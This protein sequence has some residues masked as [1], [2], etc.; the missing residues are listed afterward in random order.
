MNALLIGASGATGK[1]LLELLLEDTE[2]TRVDIFVRRNLDIEH[3]KL[4]I[5]I[6]DFDKPEQWQ[7][8]VHGDVLF[9][10]LGTTLKAAGSKEA[11]MKIDHDYQLQFARAAKQNNLTSYVLVSSGLASASSPFFYTRMKGLLEDH[12][13]VLNFPKIIIFNPPAL[14]RMHSDRKMEVAAIKV[15]HFFNSLGMFRSIKPLPTNVLAK[16]MVNA[17]KSLENGEYSIKGQQIWDY[18]NR[19]VR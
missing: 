10:C 17:V 18:A 11:Q 14:E 19:P 16:A 4:H 15:F 9:S 8:L 6:I 1:D 7:H 12:V 3:E 13:K 5:H 2:I